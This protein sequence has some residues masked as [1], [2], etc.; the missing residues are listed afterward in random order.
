[1]E[2]NQRFT[3]G[4]SIRNTVMKKADKIVDDGLIPGIKSR[5]GLIEYALSKVFKEVLKES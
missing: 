5:S 4:V 2:P 3:V 1:M